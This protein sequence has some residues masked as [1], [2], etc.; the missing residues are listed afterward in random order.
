M[1]GPFAVAAV[2]KVLQRLLNRGIT[3]GVDELDAFGNVSVTALPP[4]RIVTTPTEPTQLNLFMYQALVN[5]A[6][7]NVGMPSHAAAGERLTNPP[8][9]LDLHYLLT[10]YGEKE[11]FAEALL[12]YGM[13]MLN[14]TPVLTRDFIR[15]TWTSPTPSDAEKALA[16]SNLADQIELIKISPLN[17][18]IEEISKLWTA[19]QAKYR[20]TAA[21]RVSVVLIEGARPARTPL[22][23]LKRG[24]DDRG[25]V[26][27][28]PPFPSLAR[29]Y[30]ARA[31]LLPAVR[32]GDD[33]VI[34]GDQLNDASMVRVTHTRLPD[35]IGSSAAGLV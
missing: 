13:Q 31:E 28:A 10:A 25:P 22:P 26:V 4:D 9:G 21:Y 27:V 11:F 7:R 8:L 29:A 19:I 18:N 32:L 34:V 20:P 14:E 30:P 5:T 12:G 24:R 3:G 33:L 17:L 2:S 6:W 15:E 23:V 1:S 35:P 16:N